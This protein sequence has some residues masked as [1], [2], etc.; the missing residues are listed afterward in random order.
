MMDDELEPHAPHR[1]ARRTKPPPVAVESRLPV[2]TSCGII[3]PL[4]LRHRPIAAGFFTASAL[5]AREQIS[6]NESV[7]NFRN[8]HQLLLACVEAISGEQILRFSPQR[9]APSFNK[10]E[11]RPSRRSEVRSRQSSTA[12]RM[13]SSA[14]KSGT[15]T[16]LRYSS[17]SRSKRLRASGCHF[18]KSTVFRR[19]RSPPQRGSSTAH[20]QSWRD[21]PASRSSGFQQ[22]PLR[23]PFVTWRTVSAISRFAAVRCSSTR[24]LLPGTLSL[25]PPPVRYERSHTHELGLAR[26]FQV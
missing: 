12:R 3:S 9:G 20:R 18:V 11:P 25:A 8:H 23:L 26:R 14:S 21:A 15:L 1:H 4:S 17:F 10:A 7:Q 6:R 19:V 24:C 2:A 5:S 13:H 16:L 22:V